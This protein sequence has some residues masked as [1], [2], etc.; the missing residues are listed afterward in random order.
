[1]KVIENHRYENERVQVDSTRFVNCDFINC[2]MVFSGTGPVIFDG[3]SMSLS[4]WAIDGYAQQTID[5][6]KQMYT[7]PGLR[8]VVDK[9][10]DDIRG[11]A[12]GPEHDP[13]RPH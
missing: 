6:M 12:Q 10:I 8:I 5:F 1:M 9:T 11:A 4:M 13:A 7:K 3:G 2:T